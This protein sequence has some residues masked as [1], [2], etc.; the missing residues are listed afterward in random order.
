MFDII[1]ELIEAIKKDETYISYVKANHALNDAST[2]TLL[3]RRQTLMEDYNRLKQY[4]Q[5]TSLDEMK[6]DIQDVNAQIN[7]ND[8]IMNY[9]HCYYQ[10]N[11]MLEKVTDMI[12]ENISDELLLSRFE[13]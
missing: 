9:Y 11:D 3:S 8:I 13:L 7:Q 6:N 10:L 12:F 4:E 5:Y 1:D 2:L